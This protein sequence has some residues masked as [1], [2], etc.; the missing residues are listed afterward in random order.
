[1]PRL[2][3]HIIMLIDIHKLMYCELLFNRTLSRFLPKAFSHAAVTAATT[4]R[5]QIDGAP[6]GC[7]LSPILFSIYT[8]DLSSNNSFL[9]LIKYTDDMALAGRLK[10]ER[11]LYEYLLQI[12]A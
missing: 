9:T 10:D 5:G 4:V 11:S 7:V 1:M 2:H 8:N 6:Q 12:D 3:V